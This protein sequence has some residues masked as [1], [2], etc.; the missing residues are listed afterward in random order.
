MP[1]YSLI[2]PLCEALEVTVPELLEGQTSYESINEKQLIDLLRKTQQLENQ[3]IMLYGI[4]FSTMG[5]SMQAL[6]RTSGSH[7]LSISMLILY[8]V[9]SLLG[10][11]MIIKYL[12][13]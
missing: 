13:K 10:L 1:D 9:E 4:I 5:V 7:F 8:V 2:N 3:K 11:G 12:L 6:A